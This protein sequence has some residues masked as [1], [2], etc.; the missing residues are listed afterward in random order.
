MEV[1]MTILN[2]MFSLLLAAS[3]SATPAGDV[4]IPP[5]IPSP[6]SDTIA[7]TVHIHTGKNGDV[8][9]EYRQGGQL[10]M[11]RVTPLHGKPYTLRDTNGDGK[12]DKNDNDGDVSPVFWTL[13]EWQ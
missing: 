3:A 8:I 13:A 12:L 6:P 7:P 2:T 5:K 4:P 10:F 9:Q 11:V 1:P